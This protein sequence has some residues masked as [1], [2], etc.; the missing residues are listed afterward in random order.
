MKADKKEEQYI[1]ELGKRISGLREKS[2][3]SVQELAQKANLTRM[4]IY[5][6]EGGE[7]VSSIL[8]L[9]RIAEALGIKLDALIIG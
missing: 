6:I 7:Q 1:I 5:R 2:G 4:Y 9:R 8:V 3:L